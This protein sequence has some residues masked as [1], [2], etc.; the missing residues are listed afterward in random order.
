MTGNTAPAIAGRVFYSP[1]HPALS[2]EGRGFFLRDGTIEPSPLM[3]EG[4]VR[5]TPR[6]VAGDSRRRIEP[7]T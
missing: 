6:K 2:R 7:E 1:P 5:V 4:R 3:G